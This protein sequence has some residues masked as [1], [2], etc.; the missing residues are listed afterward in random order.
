MIQKK[1]KGALDRSDKTFDELSRVFKAVKDKSKNVDDDVTT[2]ELETLKRAFLR[3]QD[4][5]S[6]LNFNQFDQTAVDLYWESMEA[7]DLMEFD[8]ASEQDGYIENP[9]LQLEPTFTENDDAWLS[10]D[11]SDLAF[12]RIVDIDEMQEYEDFDESS[13]SLGVIRDE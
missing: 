7:H 11:Y 1:H 3:H 8:D 13:F 10:N 5:P 9:S 4:E 12:D 2:A 6:E